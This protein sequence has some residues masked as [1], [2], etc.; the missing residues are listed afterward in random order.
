[1]DVNA[2]DKTIESVLTGGFYRVPR[3]QRPY[4]WDSSNVEDFWDDVA[5]STSDYFIGSMVIFSDGDADGVVDGQQRLTTITMM[6]AALRNE[7]L[8]LG[9]S[10][11]ATGIQTLIE[12]KDSRGKLRFVLRTES[13]YLKTAIQAMPGAAQST[14]AATAE[15]RDLDRAF[16]LVTEWTGSVTASALANKALSD[17]KQNQQAKAEIEKLRDKLYGLTV[18]LVEVGEE[19]DATTIFQTLNS[20]G[21][22][23]ETADL[24]KAHLLQMLKAPN[25]QLDQARDQWDGMRESFDESAARISANRF[26]LHSWLSREEY[27]GEKDLFKRIKKRIRTNN[28]QGYLHDLVRDAERYRTAQEPSYRTWKKPQLPIAN[29]LNAMSLFRLQ[30]Q[31]PFVLSVLREYDAKT[32]KLAVLLKALHGVECFHFLA[33]AV[34]NQP[35]SGGISRMYALAARDVLSGST[36]TKKAD[37]IDALLTKLRDR[38][39]TYPEFEAAFIELRSSRVHTQQTPLVRYALERLHITAPASTPT[40]PIDLDQLTVEHLIPQGKKRPASV[41][42]DDVAR[43]GNLLLVTEKLNDQLEDKAFGEKRKVLAK[44]SG[45]EPEI[46]RVK[47]WGS[48]EI[49][50]RSKRMAKR[51][52]DDVWDF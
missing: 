47:S 2:N 45:I 9:A 8:E 4:S 7:F 51:A 28:A 29:S 18:V 43:I 11:E 26:L 42:A 44:L 48:G 32:I 19:D 13:S 27:V 40:A 25:V 49:I 34:T 12:R 21:K 17:A 5:E 36:P 16:E 46:V 6:L 38:R 15:E 3:F 14:T 52:Y 1:M 10:D 37:A 50:A 30:Q 24:V 23:L 31:L 33:T 35:S 20:R 41:P 22:D 39:P